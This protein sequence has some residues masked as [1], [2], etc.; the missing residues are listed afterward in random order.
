MGLVLLVLSVAG[1]WPFPAPWPVSFSVLGWQTVAASLGTVGFTA[2]LAAAS[3]GMALAMVGLWLASTPPRWDAPVTPVV[4]APLVLPPLMLMAGLYQGALHLRLDGQAAGVLWAHVLV[5]LPYVFI[6]L[7]PAWRDLDPRL[8]QT[9]ATLGRSRWAFRWQIQRPLLA[10]PVAAALAVGFAVSSGQF[11][12]TQMLGAG[13]WPTVTTEAVTLASG[14][15]RRTAA[16]FALLQA[17]LPAATFAA[18]WW[19][20]RGRR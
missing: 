12:A 11:L 16:A 7:R 13:R 8:A 19:F 10:A 4:L 1:P 17:L 6:V 20:Q 15:D 18:A 5:V 14:G 9:A 2:A 3:T